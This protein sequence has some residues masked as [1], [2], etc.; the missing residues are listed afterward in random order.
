MGRI[1][2]KSTLTEVRETIGLSK[3]E[4]CNPSY[5][6]LAVERILLEDEHLASGNNAIG[7]MLGI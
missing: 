3:L 2:P 6:P 4:K 1:E 5:K 7:Y